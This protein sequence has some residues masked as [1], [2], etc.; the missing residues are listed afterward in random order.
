MSALE[1]LI[2]VGSS[3]VGSGVLVALVRR[4]EKRDV[5]DAGTAREQGREET[6]R[7]KREDRVLERLHDDCREEVRAASA[8]IDSLAEENASIRVDLA[9]CEERHTAVEE[10]I[11]RLERRST[12]SID[13]PTEPFA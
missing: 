11:A 7:N 1:S 5:L 12:P 3:L 2:T 4:R 10:R 9:R 6:A 13:M 8:R